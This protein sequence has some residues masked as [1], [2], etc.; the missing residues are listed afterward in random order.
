MNLAGWSEIGRMDELARQDTEVHRLD[1]RAKIL[2]TF[3]FIVAVMS[4]PRYAVSSL[5]PF[6]FYPLALSALG[7]IP[8]GFIFRKIM[9][10]APF[11]LAV[12]IF[13]PFFDRSPACAIGPFVI[14][15]GWVSFASI[16]LRFVLTVWA[17]LALA[18]CTGMFRLCAGLERLGLPKI[19]AAQL[20]FLYRYFFVMVDEGVRM[21]RALELRS[22]GLAPV[23]LRVY[24]SLV[25]HLLLRS[26]ARSERIHR[27]MLARGFD[28][29]IKIMH[30]TEFRK[31]DWVFLFG[32]T[33]F[34]TA[35]R[36]WNLSAWLGSLLMGGMP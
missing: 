5:V 22:A 32:W 10:A 19:F 12:G 27:A 35:A 28:G 24:G 8:L 21:K 26:M 33:A 17:A 2:T 11:A 1:A 20:L 34:F 30:K 3:I 25:G 23:R 15:G 36:L 18:A 16:M 13:N 7:R 14:C 4:F 6:L 29:A 9:A 31:I